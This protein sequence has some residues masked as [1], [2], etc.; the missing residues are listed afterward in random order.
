M[1]PLSATNLAIDIQLKR[2]DTK[3]KPTGELEMKI[4]SRF[5]TDFVQRP[6]VE[7]GE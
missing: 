5:L 7:D 1:Q 4:L 3:K 6:R 2:L